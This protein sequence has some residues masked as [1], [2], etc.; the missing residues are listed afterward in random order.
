MS[1]TD[2]SAYPVHIFKNNF[3]GF[4]KYSLSLGYKLTAN[5]KNCII[6][7]PIGIRQKPMKKIQ[8]CIC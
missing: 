4:S 8:C 2:T 6:L 5:N 1:Y 3:P 7:L